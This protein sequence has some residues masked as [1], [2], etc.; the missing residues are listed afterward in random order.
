M[1]RYVTP[2]G[3]LR[4]ISEEHRAQLT[5]DAGTGEA[6]ET[7]L[8]DAIADAEAE[9]DAYV[10]QVYPLPL[11]SVPR[12]LT[13]IVV[14]LAVWHLFGRRQL[15]D[16]AVEARHKAAVRLLERI[17]AGEIALGV[18]APPAKAAGA[19]YA[20]KTDEDRLF[21]KHVMDRY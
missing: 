13:R 18:A 12:L 10:Q 21:P 19:V 8:E 6:D 16:D 2:D 14:D 11:P 15:H 7:V 4:G 9:A 5:D 17:A 20:D 1:G 3:L